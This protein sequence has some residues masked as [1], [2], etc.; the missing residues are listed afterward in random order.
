MASE[1]LTH[2]TTWA[3]KE[4][5]KPGAWF[6][7]IVLRFKTCHKIIL[8]Q[9]LRCHKMIL[10]HILSQFTKSVLGDLKYSQ[11]MTRCHSNYDVCLRLC[12]W[13][14]HPYPFYPF[15]PVPA[16][17]HDSIRP[18]AEHFHNTAINVM[19][20]RRRDSKLPYLHYTTMSERRQPLSFT[21]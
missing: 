13:Y 15:V 12:I 17:T 19:L 21:Y 3:G 16:G 20:S 5:Q 6:T 2:W 7:D 11:D 4:L 1:C 9:K 10:R 18:S 8:W 14:W